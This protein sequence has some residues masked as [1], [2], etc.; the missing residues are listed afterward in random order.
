MKR[1][2]LQSEQY[3]PSGNMAADG[4]KKLLG[5]PSMDLLHTMI[6]EAIQNSC[7]A[8]K[9]APPTI[10]FRLRELTAA[11]IDVVDTAVLAELPIG[12]R[13]RE[14]FEAF[15]T[16]EK[17][18]VLEICDFGTSG[19]TGPVRADRIPENCE[20]T[21]FVDFTRNIGSRRDTHEGGGTYG[22]GKSSLYLAS[23]CSTI[24]VDSC[25]TFMGQTV[26]RFI[27]CH[28]GE[29]FQHPDGNGYVSRYTGRHWWGNVADDGVADPVDGDAAVALAARL[30]MPERNEDKKGT[31]I[32]I[33]DPVFLQGEEPE[34]AE[35]IIRMIL[36]TVLWYF[37][38][39]MMRTTP[40]SRKLT[41]RLQLN[42]KTFSTIEPEEFPPLDL[43]C[44]AMDKIRKNTDV[45]PI[46]A[47]KPQRFLGNFAVSAGMKAMRKRLVKSDLSVIP[48]NSHHIALMRPVELVVKYLQGEAI[49]SDTAEWAGVFVCDHGVEAAFA[50]SEPP[51]HD[52]WMPQILPKGHD[53][54]F[55]KVALRELSKRANAG[56]KKSSLA[57][58]AAKGPSVAK[59][60]SALGQFLADVADDSPITRKG[61]SKGAARI[62]NQ[63]TQ[64]EFKRLEMVGG[65]K[66]AVFEVAIN[67]GREPFRLEL[68]PAIIMDGGV[69]VAEVDGLVAPEIIDWKLGDIVSGVQTSVKIPEESSAVLTVR[70][71]MA[72]GYAVTLNTRVEE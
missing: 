62:K 36:E 47:Q 35:N 11:Q 51:A 5:A 12:N 6:R 60:A 42:D 68:L 26:R 46:R 50:A 10:W 53:K 48:V 59:V 65:R 52:D 22:Y 40:A 34:T 32:A 14:G 25:S 18:W 72:G 71:A 69:K 8:A 41:V 66:A 16:R 19:L 55:V 67:A 61:G 4:F 70:V 33:V 15:R 39:R 17:R 43:Y 38:P 7:D 20:D 30:G 13:S 64:P 63:F 37:W 57:S 31:T 24:L 3:S 56:G 27:G 54:T 29:A 1:L 58:G 28:L 21:D 9:T 45:E 2:G 44:E 23:A 49:P